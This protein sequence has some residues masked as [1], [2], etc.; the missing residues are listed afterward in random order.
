MSH[1]EL[2]FPDDVPDR[3]IGA[4][5]RLGVG[6]PS[7]S[8]WDGLESRI[9]ARVAE[10]EGSPWSVLARWTRPAAIAAALLLAAASL[11]LTRLHE[12]EAAIAYGAVA[13]EQ[14]PAVDASTPAASENATTL[15]L[16]LER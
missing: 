13:E 16:L 15:H 3:E 7:A 12:R 9:L 10:E 14:Y 5:L 1:N 6:Q 8:Y 4:A 2:R 11:L